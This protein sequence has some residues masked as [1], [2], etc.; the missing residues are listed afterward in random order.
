[1]SRKDNLRVNYKNGS[2]EV[3]VENIKKIKVIGA[4]GVLD[5]IQAVIYLIAFLF[6][7]FFGF[8][9]LVAAEPPE[10]GSILAILS[11]AI[12]VG[13]PL[14]IFSA[15]FLVLF[16][17]FLVF[18]TSTRKARFVTLSVQRKNTLIFVAVLELI[19]AL[20]TTY[21]IFKLNIQHV[22]YA[23]ILGLTISL[24]APLTKIIGLFRMSAMRNVIQDEEKELQQSKLDDVSYKAAELDR[25]FYLR[26]KNLISAN[27]YATLREEVINKY[28][29]K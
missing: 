9:A 14:L 25:L 13:A 7:F 18:G 3:Y 17:L 12:G 11:E 22:L 26:E 24:P 1:M 21:V 19:V 20:I 27:E 23:V 10:E 15:V 28:S 6:C 2:P 16:I 29:K 4:S 8:T 5:F